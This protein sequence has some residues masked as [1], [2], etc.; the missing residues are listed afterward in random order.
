MPLME[1]CDS[2]STSS[3]F[4]LEKYKLASVSGTVPGVLYKHIY[5]RG[6]FNFCAAKAIASL[7]LS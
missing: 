1:K 7:K 4:G 6:Q 2:Y 5:Q 3:T